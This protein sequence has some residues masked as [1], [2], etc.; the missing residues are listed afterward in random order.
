[1]TKIFPKSFHL[2]W[3]LTEKCNLRCKHCYQEP[4]FLKQEIKTKEALKILDNFITQINQWKLSKNAVKIS[5]TGGEPLLKKDLFQLLQKCQENHSLF[6]YGILTN[7][8]L[9]TKSLISKIKDYDIDYMQI[10]LE[11]MQEVNDSIR[12]KGVFEKAVLG[13]KIAKN[14][15]INVNFAMTVTSLN[16]NEVP[17]IIALSKEIGIPLGIRRCVPCGSGK[18]I[19]DLSLSP[20]KLKLFWHY[21]LKVKNNFWRPISLGCEDGILA[22]DFSSYIPGECSAGYASFT[23][24]PNADVYPCRRLP[25]YA[26]NL[27]KESFAKIYQDSKAL[28]EL[29]N[30][31]NINDV[32][33]ACPHNN[34][35]HGG[36]KCMAFSF[37]GDTSSP[38]S[39]C[40]RLFKLLPNQKLAWKNSVQERP[41]RLNTRWIKINNDDE[42]SD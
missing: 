26:G 19:K 31:N 37:F 29:R 24:L 42:A 39:H 9:L 4:I 15:G 27:I 11:G 35:C 13:A 41:E 30:M 25:I 20:Q 17:K 6:Q 23:V 16:I 22:Q 3:H 21:I 28:R 12:G 2:Q 33:Y 18:K 10:S 36:A 14:N 38:D 40:W 32:C 5:F 1:M 7:G 34:T 8:T